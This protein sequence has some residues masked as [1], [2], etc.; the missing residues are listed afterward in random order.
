MT[1]RGD[2][3]EGAHLAPLI[4]RFA[5]RWIHMRRPYHLYL[6]RLCSP[7]SRQTKIWEEEPHGGTSISDCAFVGRG[8]GDSGVSPGRRRLQLPVGCIVA[9][10]K[11][12]TFRPR[13]KV[14]SRNIQVTS[15]AIISMWRTKTKSRTF[16][17]RSKSVVGNSS[18]FFWTISISNI[19][20]KS[21]TTIP[22]G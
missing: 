9:N 1:T 6:V 20:T 17:P 16:R 8:Q 22:R 2:G 10:K 18:P 15:T 12:R 14:V 3:G 19:S 13:S 7:L 4:A 11:S 21:S 5:T